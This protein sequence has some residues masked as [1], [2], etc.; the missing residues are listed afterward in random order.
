MEDELKKRIAE[1]VCQAWNKLDVTLFDT[2]LSEDFECVSVWVIE[3]M[4]GKD[5]YMEYITGKFDS[6]RK[7]NN[8]VTAEV[9]Y[10]EIIDKYVVV[11]DQGGNMAALEP[12][13]ENGLIKSLWMRPVEMTLPAVFTTK[14]PE[15]R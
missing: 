5:R 7:G 8:P 11:L 2:L 6:I 14:R 15:G 9:M 12:T 1:D 13:I 4:K 10:Q 3:T